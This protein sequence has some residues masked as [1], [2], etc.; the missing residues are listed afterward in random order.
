[1]LD[2][3]FTRGSFETEPIEIQIPC[4]KFEEIIFLMNNLNNFQQILKININQFRNF[5]N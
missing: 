5:K 2:T 3:A 4:S 1:M